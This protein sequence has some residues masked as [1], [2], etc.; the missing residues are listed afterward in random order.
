MPKIIVGRVRVVLLVGNY[1]IKIV[2]PMALRDGL[3]EN[4]IELEHGVKPN[5]YLAPV[6]FGLFA[7][8]IIVMARCKPIQSLQERE[9]KE[10]FLSLLKEDRQDVLNII[11]ASSVD[12]FGFLNDHVVAL[13]YGAD[14]QAQLN[15]YI[16]NQ[17][18]LPK[19][20]HYDLPKRTEKQ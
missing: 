10:Y 9:V 11:E 3:C 15:T 12:N 2:H 18:Y 17:D 13:D 19:D 8:L 14:K 1:A 7:G 6:W 4:R 20:K 16:I 5:R